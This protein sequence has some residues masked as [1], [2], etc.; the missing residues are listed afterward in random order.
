MR[1]DILAKNNLHGLGRVLA[2]YAWEWVSKKN[3]SKPDIEIEGLQLFW[4]RAEKDWVNSE[5]SPEEVGSIHVIQGYDLNFAG[6]VIGNELRWNPSKQKIEFVMT[7]YFDKRGRRRNIAAQRQSFGDEHFLWL[8]QNIYR[9]LLTR[10]IKGT[11]VYVCD[12]EL[13]QH[14]RKYFKN[15][16]PE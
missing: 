11:Y 8:M 6:V 10:G 5:T 16:K 4:N 14:L 15:I 7:N 9:V 3:P 2:G 13:R 12:P 1:N